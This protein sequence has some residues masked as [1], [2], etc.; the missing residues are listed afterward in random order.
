MADVDRPTRRARLLYICRSIDCD[1]LGVFLEQ[2]TQ[3]TLT[4]MNALNSG[5]H[6]VTSRL[7]SGQLKALVLRMESLLV[8]L[9]QIANEE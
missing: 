4:L 6:V 8:F 5:T 1:A 2:D 7:T 3:S 9:L